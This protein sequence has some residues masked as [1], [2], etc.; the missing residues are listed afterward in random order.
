M[1]N[2]EKNLKTLKTVV[3][4]MGALL[5]VGTIAL[6]IAVFFKAK[7]HK[8]VYSKTAA[9]ETVNCAYK[10]G[11]VKVDGDIKSATTNNNLLTIATAK[12]VVVYDLCEGRIL[13]SVVVSPK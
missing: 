8:E 11:E 1:Q 9:N 5:I 12:A 3:H 13:S 7:A 2:E 6:F 4:G 10:D